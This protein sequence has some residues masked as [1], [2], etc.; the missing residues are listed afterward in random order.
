MEENR[1]AGLSQ[2]L[3]MEK[4]FADRYN[5]K[6]YCIE[7][8]ERHVE[9]VRKLIIPANLLEYEVIDGW[10]PLCE[11]LDVSIPEES[12][13]VANTRDSFISRQVLGK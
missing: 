6:H 3:I 12:F 8:Y 10:Q 13:P 7:K 4:F 2:Q 1:R 9:S 11:F 5:G